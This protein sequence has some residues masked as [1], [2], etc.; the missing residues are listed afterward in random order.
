MSLGNIVINNSR[1]KKKNNQV[2][3]ILFF[4]FYKNK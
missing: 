3:K 2:D 1:K 4:Q